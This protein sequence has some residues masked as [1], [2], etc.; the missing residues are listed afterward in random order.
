M[1]ISKTLS[2]HLFRIDEI[3]NIYYTNLYKSNPILNF[4]L[5]IQYY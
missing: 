1:F 4:I 3:F 2:F 5:N